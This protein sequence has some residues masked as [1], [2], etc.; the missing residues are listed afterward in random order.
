[1][2]CLNSSALCSIVSSRLAINNQ[3]SAINNFL[4]WRVG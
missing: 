2:R 4:P 3:K 1:V